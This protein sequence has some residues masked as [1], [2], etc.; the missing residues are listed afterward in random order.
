MLF[1]AG[2]ELDSLRGMEDASVLVT[3]LLYEQRGG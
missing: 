3:I 1:L 2:N